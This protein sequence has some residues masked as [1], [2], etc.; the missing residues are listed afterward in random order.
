MCFKAVFSKKVSI[1]S[2]ILSLVCSLLECHLS[3]CCSYLFVRFRVPAGKGGGGGGEEECTPIE[4]NRTEQNR[5]V[6]LE[7]YTKIV[8]KYK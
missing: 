3:Q 5:Y 7:S 6:Y 4:Q 1:I 2:R 8:Q